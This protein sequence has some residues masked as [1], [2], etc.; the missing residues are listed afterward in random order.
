[1][2]KRQLIYEPMTAFTDLII[3]ILGS[4]FALELFRHFGQTDI[5]E[6]WYWSLAFI[7]V[8]L[9]AFFGAVSHGIGPHFSAIVKNVLW[10]LTTLS[11]GAVAMFFLFMLIHHLPGLEKLRWLPIS[12]YVIYIFVILR[13]DKF[14][15]V[16]RYYVPI[17]FIV[18]LGMIYSQFILHNQGVGYVSIGII[19]SF[20]GAGVQTSRFDLHKHFNHN[21]IYHVI[22]MFG[23]WF[24]FKGAM[25]M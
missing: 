13:D 22:Q 23:M 17:M 1:M 7:M 12:I 15:N 25:M 5:A 24:L 21:D 14:L 10:K 18:L 3:A 8:S 4:Y 16:I 2:E 20:V 6:H 11:I 19:I 9:G